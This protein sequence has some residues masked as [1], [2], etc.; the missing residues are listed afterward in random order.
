[1]KSI[2]GRFLEDQSG[3]T[4]VEYGVIVAVIGMG[5]VVGLSVIRDDLNGIF[6][7]VAGYMKK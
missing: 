4:A 2:I 6:T 5:I 3:A 7:N 1:M